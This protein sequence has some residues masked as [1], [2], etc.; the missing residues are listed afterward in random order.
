MDIETRAKMEGDKARDLQ[1]KLAAD[2]GPEG[3][4]EPVDG[5]G[6]A[7][8]ADGAEGADGLPTDGAVNP[9]K[10]Q[11]GDP[12][13]GPEDGHKPEQ[14]QEEETYRHKFLTLQGMYNSEKRKN[15]ARIAELEARV[16]AL[17]KKLAEPV[18]SEP[19]K[20]QGQE[21][22][23][24]TVGKIDPEAFSEYGEEFKT[25]A[26]M[27]N[28]LTAEN[29]DLKKKVGE[30]A[31]QVEPL[32]DTVAESAKDRFLAELSRLCPDAQ[33]LNTDPA[34]LGWLSEVNALDPQGRTR[35]ECLSAAASA[36]RAAPAAAYFNE[37]LREI[38]NGKGS[39]PAAPQAS[40]P[41]RSATP[42]NIQPSGSGRPSG[43][44][45][46]QT[47]TRAEIQKF[48]RDLSRGEFQGDEAAVLRMKNNIALAA[49]EGRISE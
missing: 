28:D 11:E 6:Q 23:A 49:R 13:P 42:K 32:R 25:L 43:E 27:V 35:Q 19:A 29:E 3:T 16:D 7:K 48:Y 12:K 8:P 1:A 30:T 21:P 33:R 37:F 24:K 36:L 5:P 38:G 18:K 39:Q 9:E 17:L 45:Q 15:E 40:A 41:Q 14:D 46:P 2:K 44:P 31:S 10:G 22:P 26:R 20:D 47:F 4:K 34:F